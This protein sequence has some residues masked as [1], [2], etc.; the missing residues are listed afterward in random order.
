MTVPWTGFPL[1]ALVGSPSRWLPPNISAW[2]RSS[3]RRRRPGQRQFWFP[4]PMSR[5]LTIA[6]ATNEL[7][8]VVTGAYGKP[9]AKSM[10]API[11]VHLPWKYGFKSIK[12]IGVHLRRGSP[13]EFLAAGQAPDPTASGP[14][15]IPTCRIRAGA[16][17]ASATSHRRPHSDPAL[18]RLWRFCRRALH[19]RGRRA[20]VY[21]SGEGDCHAA[22]A[23]WSA[24]TS[25]RPGPAYHRSVVRAWSRGRDR[26]SGAPRSRRC[27][28]F[29]PRQLW[30]AHSRGRRERRPPSQRRS[31]RRE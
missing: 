7:A 30:S 13:L 2:K 26:A 17:R 24:I 29:P 8:F 31:E 6:E 16:R 25:R 14:T 12:S 1:A 21:V 27:R 15:S 9:V 28:A 5:A 11:R 20:A 18:Q 3:T 4:G 22:S 10:G 23:G 19:R